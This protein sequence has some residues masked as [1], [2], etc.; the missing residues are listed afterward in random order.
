MKILPN[1]HIVFSGLFS[2]ESIFSKNFITML[3]MIIKLFV[4][5]MC[6]FHCDFLPNLYIFFLQITISHFWSIDEFHML[7]CF[8]VRTKDAAL[9]LFHTSRSSYL[10]IIVKHC[11]DSLDINNELHIYTIK[12]NML[13]TGVRQRKIFLL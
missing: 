12:H 6:H 9:D 7:K 8:L 3:L 4:I 11:K 13:C 10:F 1:N 2:F 5:Y